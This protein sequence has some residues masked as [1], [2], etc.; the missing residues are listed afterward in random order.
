MGDYQVSAESHQNVQAQKK[1]G[2]FFFFFLLFWGKQVNLVTL[3]M[4]HTSLT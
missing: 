4:G 3:L 1:V 2:T